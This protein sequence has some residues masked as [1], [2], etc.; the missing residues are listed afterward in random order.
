MTKKSR[1]RRVLN[2]SIKQCKKYID[3]EM[4]KQILIQLKKENDSFFDYLYTGIKQD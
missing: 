1:D 2:R 4:K 3:V